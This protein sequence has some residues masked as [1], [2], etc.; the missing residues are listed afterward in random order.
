MGPSILMTL[1]VMPAPCHADPDAVDECVS[2]RRRACHPHRADVRAGDGEP[3]PTGSMRLESRDL[4]M[5][6]MAKFGH[7]QRFAAAHAAGPGRVFRDLTSH[8]DA[9]RGHSPLLVPRHWLP[10]IG[11]AESRETFC[12][13]LNATLHAI[14][15]QN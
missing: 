1:F 10:D 2:R 14:P 7:C 15:Y 5:D 8:P 3:I 13:S 4:D 12:T 9:R 6:R 11:C